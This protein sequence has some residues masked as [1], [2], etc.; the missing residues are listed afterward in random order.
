[1]TKFSGPVSYKMLWINTEDYNLK[2]N[3]RFYEMSDFKERMTEEH[4]QL[5]GRMLKLENFILGDDFK[6]IDPIQQALLTVQL[7]AM[8]TY[9]QC[10]I[11]RMTA[12]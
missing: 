2:P 10:L 8:Q 3:V 5:G 1:M 11:A 4:L 6:L 9:D 12:L 7:K